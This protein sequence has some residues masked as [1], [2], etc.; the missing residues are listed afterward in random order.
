MMDT[1]PYMLA[2]LYEGDFEEGSERVVQAATIEARLE[3]TRQEALTIRVALRQ[4]NGRKSLYDDARL[5][6][7]NED[8]R[9]LVT[10]VTYLID[11]AES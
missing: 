7:T 6:L 2:S 5:C 3:Q 8:A 4:W 11:L 9:E 10:A 1:F